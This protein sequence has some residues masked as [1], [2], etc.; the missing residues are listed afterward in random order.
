[1]S[2]SHSTSTTTGLR[3]SLSLPLITFYGLGN[4]LGA[5]IYVLIG[6]V[7]GHAGLF[8][9]LSF[10]LASLLA[11]L[12][13]FS[14][15]ELSAR[16]PLSAGEAVYVQKGLGVRWLA[17]VVGLLIIFSGCV[18]AAT[19]LRGFVGYQ[20][21]F[22][23]AP[24]VI[25]LPLTVLLLGGLAAWGITQSVAI[26]ALFTVVEIFG[27]LLII[28]VGA[29]ELGTLR[30]LP[31]DVEGLGQLDIWIGIAVGSFLAFFAFIGFEDMVNVAEEVHRPE[32]TMPRA[33][34]LA[35]A[36][37]TLLYIAVALVAL[38][39]LPPSELADSEAPLAAIYA[40]L[41]GREP[42]LITFIG[43]FAVINGALIQMIMVSRIIYGMAD[44]G[45]LPRRLG[46]IHRVTRTPVVATVL[47]ASLVLALALSGT[48]EALAKATTY[49]LLL[50]F[51]LANLSLW[52]IKREKVHPPGIIR[53]PRWVPALGCIAS[54]AVIL[55]QLAIDLRF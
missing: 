52:R 19:I 9:P 29:P 14:Y 51:G 35:L 54:L 8:A 16:F 53:I 6:K 30:S 5:G 13:A 28:G 20:Q 48:T 7:A 43:M 22:V 18:S 21:V 10:V 37:S 17:A 44:R 42:L 45:W 33:I 1:M 15:A 27:L 31:V 4:I 50:V 2:P 36:F 39:T 24:E 26:A 40:T 11:G 46:H 41:T 23:P 3:R 38:S 49:G 47:V 32:H 25:V 34:L 55:I 12:T